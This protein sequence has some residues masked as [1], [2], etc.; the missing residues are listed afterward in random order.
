MVGRKAGI[1]DGNLSGKLRRGKQPA[2]RSQQRA[3]RAHEKYTHADAKKA[4]PETEA[5]G[6]GTSPAAATGESA[7]GTYDAYQ[8]STSDYG[9]STQSPPAPHST[10]APTPFPA[11]PIPRPPPTPTLCLRPSHSPPTLCP[12]PLLLTLLLVRAAAGDAVTN[13][14]A[15]LARSDSQTSRFSVMPKMDEDVARAAS[16][17]VESGPV[18]TR[19][20]G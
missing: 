14:P 19:R 18:G 6:Y 4:I 15:S 12:R 13:R 3:T 20:A 2:A 1:R 9:A 11:H 17:I 16:I 5:S 10:P 8:G 7:Y